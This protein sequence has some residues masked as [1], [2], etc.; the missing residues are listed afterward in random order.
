MINFINEWIMAGE[1]FSKTEKFIYLLLIKIVAVIAIIIFFVVLS[2]VAMY[3]NHRGMRKRAVI[4]DTRN[5]TIA[6]IIDDLIKY[7]FSIICLVTILPLLGVNS[8]AI[9]ASSG[10]LAIVISVGGATFINDFINGFF[11]LFEG[12]FDVGDFVR[13]NSHEGTI[14][15]IGL[16]TTVL[17]SAN[18]E[19]IAIPNSTIVEVVNL[20][21]YDFIQYPVASISYD[22][23]VDFVL[24]KVAPEIVENLKE[25]GL[26][27]SIKCLGV[28]EL[29][30]SCVNI[31][32]EIR[33][34]A[35]DR[36]EVERQFYYH[37]KTIF[38]KHNIEI[39][40]N[41]L[42]LHNANE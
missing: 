8:K 13:I 16:K 32:F 42:V 23:D 14:L 38:D 12:Y 35:Q 3:L 27:T 33:S 21:K 1:S 26:F 20:S 2:K 19:F 7:V 15:E 24:E 34:H 18:N 5:E 25:T 4:S 39:P 28:T 31:K 17:L 10:V 9:L 30:A 36:F 40:F 29:A 6:S 11:A 37:V 41:Q 22:Q